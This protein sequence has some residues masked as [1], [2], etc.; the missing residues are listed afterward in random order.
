MA[1][2]FS[3]SNAGALANVNLLMIDGL[4]S[5]LCKSHIV[6]M[7]P[8]TPGMTFSYLLLINLCFI[9]FLKALGRDSL[10]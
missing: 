7:P 1:A 3:I 9:Q 4:R 2:S 5:N 10:S 8:A 6:S